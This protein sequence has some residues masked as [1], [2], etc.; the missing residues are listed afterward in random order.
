LDVGRGVL[1]GL[2]VAVG[3][4]VG[5]TPESV[6]T[7]SEGDAVSVGRVADALG[8]GEPNGNVGLVLEVAVGET[9][10]P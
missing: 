5:G 4:V 8:E 6:G 2:G 9:S 10:A 3:P 7:G 1:V